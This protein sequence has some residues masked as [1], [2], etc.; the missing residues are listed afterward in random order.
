ML[1]VSGERIT[2]LWTGMDADHR[3]VRIVALVQVEGRTENVVS[4]G[5]GEHL[6]RFLHSPAISLSSRF[7]RFVFARFAGSTARTAAGFAA[8]FARTTG[9]AATPSSNH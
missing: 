3:F 5:S 1:E 9:S 2:P 7:T 6:V 8:G 4:G